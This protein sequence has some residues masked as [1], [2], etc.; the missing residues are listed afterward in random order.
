MKRL[1]VTLAE[2]Q[3]AYL[4]DIKLKHK[5]SMSAQIRELVRNSMENRS[6]YVETRPH[7]RPL[8][9]KQTDRKYIPA[10]NAE[11]KAVFAKMR[12]KH[13]ILC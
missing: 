11:L 6:L 12:E 5:I 3:F 2:E 9:S 8:W 4:R 10:L 7:S 13:S 1:P